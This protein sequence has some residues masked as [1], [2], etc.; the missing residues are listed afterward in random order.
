V[1]TFRPLRRGEEGARE[2]SRVTFTLP[3]EGEST[4]RTMVHAQLDPASGVGG[5]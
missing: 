1:M 3:A 2:I 5:G 4:R